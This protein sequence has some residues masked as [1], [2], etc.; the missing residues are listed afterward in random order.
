METD[1]GRFI[2]FH[3][4]AWLSACGLHIE[5]GSRNSSLKRSTVCKLE[6]KIWTLF[7]WTSAGYSSLD[8]AMLQ[9]DVYD[10][11]SIPWISTGYYPEFGFRKT[12]GDQQR[13]ISSPCGDQTS[14]LV[15]SVFM[16]RRSPCASLSVSVS[17][18][19]S[20]IEQ[21]WEGQGPNFYCTVRA[22]FEQF[23]CNSITSR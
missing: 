22:N 10:M 6:I 15:P 13:L 17:M 9:Y 16:C 8:S 4:T 14:R 18:W 5:D 23:H 11:G 7:P 2:E 1:H 12:S 19:H 21:C 20:F 3:W